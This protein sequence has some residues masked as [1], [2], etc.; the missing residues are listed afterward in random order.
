MGNQQLCN[1]SNE[2]KQVV[3]SGILGDGCLYN[4]N[5]D[6]KKGNYMYLTS[7]IHKE[8]IDYKCNILS[9]LKPKIGYI[10][11]NGYCKTP[12]YTLRTLSSNILTNFSKYNLK[13][14]CDNIDELGLA[15]WF[16][17]DCSL[18]KHK[19]FYNINTQ[20]FT[21]E[22]QEEFLIPLLNRFNIFPKITK[23]VKKN[24]NVYYYLRV[25][26]FEGSFEISTILKKLPFKC[27]N[28]KLWSSETIHFWSKLQVQ[29]KSL[30]IRATNR[31]LSNLLKILEKGGSMQ[32]IVQSLEKSKAGLIAVL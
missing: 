2:F 21:K 26:K 15:L 13:T 11:E 7:C 23:E 17:D 19:L 28:Y 22:E 10:K 9:I 20:S 32:D 1:L 31:R 5:K 27:F 29:L 16:Y 8:Y 6:I 14:I 3:L 24:G 4:Q 18:H 25:S 12:I 30:G